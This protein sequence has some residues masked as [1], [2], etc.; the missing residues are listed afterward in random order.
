M[1]ASAGALRGRGVGLPV[2]DLGGGTATPVGSIVPTVMA[3][4]APMER[5]IER[6]TTTG[7]VAE[8]GAAG[9]GLGGRRPTCSD[10]R[11]RNA[12]RLIGAGSR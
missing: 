11:I 9:K 3:A 6:E 8:R 1:P 12:L 10:A 4:L 7:S 2:L 5:Q